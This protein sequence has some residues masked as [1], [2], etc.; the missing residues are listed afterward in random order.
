MLDQISRK[1]RSDHIGP[2]GT[3]QNLIVRLS[4]LAVVGWFLE[5]AV[6]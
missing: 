5:I 6:A 3:G 2:N 1:V 4:G